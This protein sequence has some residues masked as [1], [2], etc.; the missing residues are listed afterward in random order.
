MSTLQ[1]FLNRNLVD[2][3]TKEVAISDRLR[4]ENGAL[5]KAKING[6]KLSGLFLLLPL[7]NV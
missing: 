5:L 6:A 7:K 2:N 1:D 4:D 3:L